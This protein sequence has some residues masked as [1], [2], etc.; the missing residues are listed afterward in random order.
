MSDGWAPRLIACAIGIF[1]C[2]LIV[3][4]IFGS[5]IFGSSFG[6]LNVPR[7]VVIRH[8]LRE[9]R[10]G[11]GF[12]L[13]RKDKYGLRGSYGEPSEIDILVVGGSTSNE[14][15]VGEGETWADVMAKELRRYSKTLRVANA[16]VDG[17]S[18]VGHIRS[19]EAWF[20]EIPGLQPKYVLFYVGINDSQL[21]YQE[22]FDRLEELK[23]GARL[24]RYVKNNSALYYLVRLIRGW[25]RASRANII[26][27]HDN[28][29]LKPIQESI[30]VVRQHHVT[31]LDAYA[32]RI[33]YLAEQTR[34]M[35]AVPIFVTQQRGGAFVIDG[36]TQ[37]INRES[38]RWQAVQR[39]YN[40]T[41]MTACRATGGICIDLASEIIFVPEDFSDLLH[42]TASGSRKIG[43]YLAAKLKDQI[44]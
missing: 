14:F 36:V 13:Y 44:P 11:G 30:H 12:A 15:Y 3:E 7:N 16:G 10:P 23:T 5:W 20:P 43:R 42:T 2:L 1:L 17:H 24:V 19:F 4:T 31:A 27:R 35:G 41:L 26:Y 25:V 9:I 22:A 34:K 39:L 40:A 18:T 33:K 37:A 6:F 29:P 8:D 38:V 21:E 32:G 28:P